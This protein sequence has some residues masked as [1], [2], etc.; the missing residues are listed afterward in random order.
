MLNEWR[1]PEGFQDNLAFHGDQLL[2]IRVETPDERVPPYTAPIPQN[3]PEL[4][5]CARPSRPQ[6]DEM[7]WEL[8]EFNWHVFHS[9]VSPDGRY[10]VVEGLGGASSETLR[11]IAGLYDVSTGKLARRS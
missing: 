3:I 4:S 5:A 1:L 11:R 10:L 7:A 6:S 9:A 8:R 2:S